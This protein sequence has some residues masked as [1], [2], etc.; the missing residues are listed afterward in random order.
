MSRPTTSLGRKRTY[1]KSC[2]YRLPAAWIENVCGRCLDGLTSHNDGESVRAWLTP[3][4][5]AARAFKI[6]SGGREI[7][8]EI[9]AV[10]FRRTDKETVT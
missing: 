3:R 8:D 2:N 9:A 5:A 6:Q 10:I 1:C 4:L 7:S